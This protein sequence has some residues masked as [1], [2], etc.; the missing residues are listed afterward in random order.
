MRK[1]FIIGILLLSI[2]YSNINTY[3]QKLTSRLKIARVKYSGGG[4][5]YNDPSG[6]VNMLKYIASNTNIQVDPV[7]EY[8]DLASDNLFLYPF[9]FLT[10]H[11]NINFTPQEVKKLRAYLQNGGFLYVDDDYGLD[12]YIHK[13][14][15]KIFPDQ[16]FVELPFSHSIYNCHFKFPKGLPKIHEHDAKPPQGFGLFSNDRL[17]V[18]YTFECNLGDGWVD[19]N[20]Y[21][22]PAEIRDASFKMGVNIIIYALTN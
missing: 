18:F 11:G 10:G 1:I 16:D 12:P 4:D 6:E 8:V 3:S 5:W 19:A 2:T 15:K 13:E 21:N 20:V 14:M 22:D 9:I 17:C 7:F